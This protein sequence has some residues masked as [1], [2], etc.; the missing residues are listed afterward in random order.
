[1]WLWN[2]LSIVPF[3]GGMLCLYFAW[4]LLQNGEFLLA[5]LLGLFGIWSVRGGLIGMTRKE[6][7]TWSS[8]STNNYESQTMKTLTAEEL[9]RVFESEVAKYERQGWRVAKRSE[10]SGT[11]FALLYR[12]NEALNLT[13]DDKGR[14]YPIILRR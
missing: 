11:P 4:G 6:W 13:M 1:M 8:H 3:I 14:T 2:L 9:K 12:G 5:I 7:P 10:I